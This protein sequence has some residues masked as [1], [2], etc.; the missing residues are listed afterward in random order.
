MPPDHRL[1]HFSSIDGQVIINGQSTIWEGFQAE[2]DYFNFHADRIG[3]LLDG[4][5]IAITAYHSEGNSYAYAKY[6]KSERIHGIFSSESFLM[7]DLIHE[8]I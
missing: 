4:E 2:I 3:E 7:K 6:P 8:I 5:G 1:T